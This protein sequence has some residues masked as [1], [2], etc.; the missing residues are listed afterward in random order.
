M[1]QYFLKTVETFVSY[2]GTGILPLLFIASAIYI[3]V[4]EKITWK[5][6]ILGVTPLFITVM[7]FMPFMLFYVSRGT[8]HRSDLFFAAFA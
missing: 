5:K 1:L 2:C 8:P 6:M 3:T 4:T 7:F